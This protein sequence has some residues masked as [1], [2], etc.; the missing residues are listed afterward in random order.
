[1]FYYYRLIEEEEIIIFNINVGGTSGE[2]KSEG[3]IKIG[4]KKALGLASGKI[5][6]LLR[7]RRPPHT[8]RD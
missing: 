5:L 1:M 2:M 8:M 6:C 7:S 4:T 3:R